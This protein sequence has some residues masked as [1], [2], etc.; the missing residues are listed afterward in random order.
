MVMA[1]HVLK[2]KGTLEY[3]LVYRKSDK[4]LGLFAYSDSD[5]ASSVEDRK[6]IILGIVLV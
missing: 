6:S 2:L 4:L 3:E 1:K 5:W